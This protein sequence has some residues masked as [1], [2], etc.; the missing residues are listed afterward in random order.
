[1]AASYLRLKREAGT[2]I[3][4]VRPMSLS[5]PTAL[6]P[7]PGPRPVPPPPPR[8]SHIV[9]RV[10]KHVRL[11]VWRA[12]E[13]D[14]IGV[15]KG[16]AYSSILTLFPAL[17]FAASMFALTKHGAQYSQEVTGAAHRVMPP[18]TTSAVQAYFGSLQQ[19]PIGFLLGAALLTLWA[20]SGVMVSWMEGF[21][22]AY[23]MPKTWGIV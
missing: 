13:H 17:V 9:V 18:G 20:A 8:R 3:P 23:Q 11:A 2:L 16:A 1:M 6:P 19:R 12:F 7:Q 15:A 14:A 21:R 4:Y 22:K 10:L 5:E